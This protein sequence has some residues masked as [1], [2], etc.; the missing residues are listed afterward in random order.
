MIRFTTIGEFKKARRF[1]FGLRDSKKFDTRIRQLAEEGVSALSAAT[2]VDSAETASHWSYEI[3]NTPTG[4]K[5][6]WN[7]D[8]KN[9]GIPI[10]VLINYGH[11]TIN[12]N[13]VRGYDFIDRT[14]GPI[15]RKFND[16]VWREVT[17]A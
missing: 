14:I 6:Y 10:V 13:F 7:N 12:G 8:N 3:D 4:V 9:D 11:A 15:I 1:L 2:P 16:V 5:I 17:R